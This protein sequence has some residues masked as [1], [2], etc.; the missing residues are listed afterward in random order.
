MKFEI[1]GSGYIKHGRVSP[2]PV[3]RDCRFLSQW[4][5][6]ATKKTGTLNQGDRNR[7]KKIKIHGGLSGTNNQ[8]SESCARKA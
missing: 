6:G 5:W 3:M 8:S 1:D 4:G 7:N 2:N